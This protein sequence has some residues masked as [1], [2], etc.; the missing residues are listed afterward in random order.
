M[1]KTRFFIDITPPERRIYE[2]VHAYHE[3]FDGRS[4]SFREIMSALSI[5]SLSLVR[6]YLDNLEQ[7]GY[8]MARGVR[9]IVITGG[10][11]M[12]EHT[13]PKNGILEVKDQ[14]LYLILMAKGH[15]IKTTRRDGQTVFF[16]FEWERVKG[17]VEL[18][19]SNSK[20]PL[21]DARSFIIAMAISKATIRELV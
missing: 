9:N 19:K 14:S 21:E 13:E 4:P 10:Y 3:Q 11:L 20:M 7:A 16:G 12:G 2:Y 5:S 6:F 15:P 17:D 18:F 1:A 8:L